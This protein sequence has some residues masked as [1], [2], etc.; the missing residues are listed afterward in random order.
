MSANTGSAVRSGVTAAVG[1]M[2][3]AEIAQEVFAV[4]I[5]A[6]RRTGNLGYMARMFA[7]VNLPHSRPAG[8]EYV[9]RNGR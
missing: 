7:Q 8:S 6:A 9:R 4:E 5:E 3:L 2:S 1:P